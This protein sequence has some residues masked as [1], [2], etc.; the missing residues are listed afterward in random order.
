MRPAG[1]TDPVA[2]CHGGGAGVAPIATL[3][4][5]CC[6]VVGCGLLGARLL[7]AARAAGMRALGID[8]VAPAEVQGNAAE[9]SVLAA[10]RAQ[11]V[12]ELIVCCAATHGGDEGAYRAT[13]LDLPQALHAAC[14][15]AQLLFCSSSSVYGR[16][17]GAGVDEA[18]PCRAESARARLLRAAERAV[19][20]MGSGNA[21]LRLVPLY[22]GGRCELLRRFVQRE[23]ALPGEDAR[24]LN[25]IH[26]EDAAQAL[27]CLA[28]AMAAGKAPRVVN[29]CGESFTRGEVYRRLEQL[30]SLP[31]VAVVAEGGRRGLS[32]CRV[33][34]ALLR[35]LGWQPQTVFADWAARHWRQMC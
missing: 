14:P 30:T 3:A 35:S 29:A 27:L 25:Y 13:Y 18:S 33:S 31:R 32:D 11:L 15:E 20:S 21:V 4:G 9:A 26:A 16:Q 12:P 22:G 7:S 23:P 28:A 17:G 24:W 5:R 2:A 6:W 1:T 8:P 34:S 19:L 10:A